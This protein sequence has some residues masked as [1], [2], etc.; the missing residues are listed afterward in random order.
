[1]PGQAKDS[2]YAAQPAKKLSL[3]MTAHF[4]KYPGRFSET[5]MDE[6][7]FGGMLP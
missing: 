5:M 4:K 6:T 2:G 1:M 7:K 3:K